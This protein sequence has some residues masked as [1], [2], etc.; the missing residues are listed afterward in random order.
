MRTSIKITFC[1]T[2]A[3]IVIGLYVYYGQ[4]R[5][6]LDFY[7][8]V[9]IELRQN[10]KLLRPMYAKLQR[11]LVKSKLELPFALDNLDLIIDFATINS[12]LGSG[13]LPENVKSLLHG[14]L[15]TAPQQVTALNLLAVD[16]YNRREYA[17]A[18]T[19]WRRILL[20]ADENGASSSEHVAI[21]KQK[22]LETEEKAT[23]LES[24]HTK[25]ENYLE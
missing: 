14:V 15:R 25:N 4:A 2:F 1:V 6:L 24:I 9:Q 19:L 16:A 23:E 3:T 20:V 17:N 10:Q 8:P 11:E 12:K 13:F 7:A 18:V 21:L 22:V 5:Y